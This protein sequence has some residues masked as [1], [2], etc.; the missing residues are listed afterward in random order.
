MNFK[1]PKFWD[2]DKPN[3]ISY[4]LFALTLVIR[5]NNFFLDNLKFSKNKNIKTICIGNIYLGGTGKT[6][7]TIKIY[8]II[9]KLGFKVV[10]AKKF[11]KD[12]IDEQL[13][14]KEKTNLITEKTRDKIIHSALKKNVEVIVFDDGL[15]DKKVGY[16]I[17]LVCFNT[18]EWIGNGQLI[19]SG[20][21]RETL[22]SL[23]KYDGVFIKGNDL[24]ISQKISRIIKE[25]NPQIK[26]YFT[27]YNVLNL[28][29]FDLTKKYLLF[30]GIGSPKNFKNL[31]IKEN[32]KISFEMIFPD[33]YKYKISDIINMLNN[34]KNLDAKL[35][36][37][38]KDYVKIPEE[39]KHEINYL[40]VDLKINEEENL[41]N[42]LRQKLNEKN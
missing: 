19:P 13:I 42:F 11:Y 41:I 21:L 9:K 17:R 1:K 16:D 5:I 8:N 36:T 35:I 25:V 40:D 23:K 10:A 27:N 12:E 3:F 32:F 31:L 18:D 37:T 33:H 14:L 6:P 29:K 38:K 24:I 26:I 30:S 2:L 22:N 4:I 39:F 34:A 7:T 28:D 15:Q 20:P